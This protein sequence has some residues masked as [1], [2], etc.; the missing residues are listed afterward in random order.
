[1]SSLQSWI[2]SQQAKC[3]KQLSAL[4]SWMERQRSALCQMRTCLQ[5]A[6]QT[7]ETG[8]AHLSDIKAKIESIQQGILSDRNAI[9]TKAECDTESLAQ[10]DQAAFRGVMFFDTQ[11]TSELNNQTLETQGPLI[12]QRLAQ[13]DREMSFVSQNPELSS[14][15]LLTLIAMR[16]NGYELRQTASDRGLISYFEQEGTRH[17]I[18]VRMARLAPTPDLRDE[19]WELLAETCGAPGDQCLEEI[20]DF[21][22]AVQTLELGQL[23]RQGGRVC[24]KDGT[25]DAADRWIKV[26]SPDKSSTSPVVS[27]PASVQLQKN[28]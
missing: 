16:T 27:R 17:K 13:L 22:T 24:P 10:A 26:P 12:E 19:R 14:A 18:A 6:T 25:N 11:V 23:T 20:M 2:L 9:M 4:A 21:E 15:A 8:L 5:Q 28:T 3:I 7:T 1:M